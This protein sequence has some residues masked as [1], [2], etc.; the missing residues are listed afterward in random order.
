MAGTAA[1]TEL[2]HNK[3]NDVFG[4]NCLTSGAGYPNAHILELLVSKRRSC[5]VMINI[6]RSDAI[7]HSP[8]CTV[9]GCVAV[10][11]ADLHA[12]KY[13]ASFNHHDVFNALL[14]IAVIQNFKAEIRA[15]LNQI[16]DL[17]AG[18]FFSRKL[19]SVG[20]A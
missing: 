3:K 20:S 15:I 13:F 14:R 11:G 9:H 8:E 16:F 1:R 18:I 4:C 6:G 12:G 19:R 17:S 7:S 2:F 5:Q 10:P